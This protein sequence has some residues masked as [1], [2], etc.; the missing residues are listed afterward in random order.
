MP[1]DNINSG[2]VEIV[3]SLV[4]PFMAVAFTGATIGLTFA[5]KLEPEVVST[6]ATAMASFY[7]GERSVRKGFSEGVSSAHLSG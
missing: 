2:F 7:F 3:R 4:R 5:G 6:A 1:G